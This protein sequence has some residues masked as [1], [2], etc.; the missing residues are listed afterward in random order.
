MRSGPWKLHF[1]HP[2]ITVAAEPGRGG[3]PSNWGKLAP[4]AI[5]QSGVE[6]IASR[7]GYR[8]EQLEL[9]LFNLD[10]D[11]GETHNVAAAHPDVV[12]RLSAAA[13]DIRRDLGDS[14]QKVT[15]QGVR[16]PGFD[17]SPSGP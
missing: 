5:T 10:S 2:Y 6:G 4:N 9:S 12:R 14:L 17:P 16:Q 7:H 11:P 13:D 15:G 3:K 1:A 8:V